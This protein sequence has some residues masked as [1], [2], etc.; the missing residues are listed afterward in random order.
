MIAIC[1]KG[2]LFRTVQLLGTCAAPVLT[3][4]STCLVNRG[5]HVRLGRRPGI[6]LGRREK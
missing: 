2:S 1:T 3:A 6:A 4:L 5:R